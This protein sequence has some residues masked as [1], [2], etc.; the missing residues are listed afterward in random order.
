[1]VHK[2]YQIVLM[3]KQIQ[4]HLQKIVQLEREFRGVDA[5]PVVRSLLERKLLRLAGHKEVPGRPMLY[6]T[7]RRFL[8][9]FSLEKIE[10][11]PS[12]RQLEELA[13]RDDF[14]GGESDADEMDPSDT[15]EG[16]GYGLPAAGEPDSGVAPTF[17]VTSATLE[18]VEPVGKLH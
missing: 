14:D 13:P 12:L 7:S 4:H 11:L 2:L 6:G 17:E 5:G 8:E 9:V 18:E 10:D 16:E 1:M 3:N 15:P